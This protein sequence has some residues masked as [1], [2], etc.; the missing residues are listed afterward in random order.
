MKKLFFLL[1]V[2]FILF[3]CKGKKAKLAGK[4]KQN[5]GAFI[6]DPQYDETWKELD[7]KDKSC[8]G[9]GNVKEMEDSIAKIYRDECAYYKNSV[10]Q[11]NDDGSMTLTR[12]NKETKGTWKVEEGSDYTYVELTDGGKLHERWFL[13][14]R[15]TFDGD[16][17]FDVTDGGQLNREGG[18]YMT[19]D[20]KR[21]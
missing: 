10:Y 11:L 13:D 5:E 14:T 21:E 1:L 4:W 18:Y 15:E 17:H 7:E 12:D 6:H 9:C 20:L 8:G 2:P 3:S 19:Y 16:L